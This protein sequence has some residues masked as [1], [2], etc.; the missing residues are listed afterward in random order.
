[1]KAEPGI[2]LSVI[3]PVFQSASSLRELIRRLREVMVGIS[4][5]VELILVDDRSLDSSWEI[6]REAAAREGFIKGIRL[7]RNFGQHQAI[8]AGLDAAVGE[9]TVVMDADLQD[10]P[11]EIPH[12]LS[13]AQH[14]Y[15]VVLARRVRRKDSWGKKWG[16]KLFYKV[17][18]YMSGL[19][20]DPAV[21][22][23]GIYHKRV[24]N[25]LVQMRESFRYFP[26]MVHWLGFRQGTF[27]VAHGNSV[28]GDSNYVFRT[29][30][31]LGLNAL[32][33]F[34]DKPLRLTVKLGFLIASIGF[35]FAMVTLIRYFS[36]S[37]VVPGYASLIVSIWVLAGL[38][39][40]TMGLVGLYVGRIFEG[41]KNRPLYVVD[42][43]T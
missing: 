35:I 37:I 9:W 25:E 12:L 41:V 40:M 38:I 13:K 2:F 18:S 6:I 36:G 24:I 11:E 4:S 31:H 23:F 15:D 16:S 33:A 43:R 39:L 26:A 27:D 21:G 8:A 28:S 29:K 30:F 3:V 19:S 22:N 20:H 14:G 10:L 42:Q 17:F 34:S 5:Q 32:L 1:M 7:S